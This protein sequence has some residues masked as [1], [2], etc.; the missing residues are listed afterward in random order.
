ATRSR[1]SHPDAACHAQARRRVGCQWKNGRRDSVHHAYID[2]RPHSDATM[3]PRMDGGDDRGAARGREAWHK[4]VAGQLT[5]Y[6]SAP[7]IG[8]PYE[9]AEETEN[10]NHQV[11]LS[12][13][14]APPLDAICR[15]SPFLHPR[16]VSPLLTPRVSQ[17]CG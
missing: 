6:A 9:Q 7:V 2:P 11:D 13:A 8:L 17:P 14:T 5:R 10:H 12:E 1:I 15:K 4:S 16:S 3:V